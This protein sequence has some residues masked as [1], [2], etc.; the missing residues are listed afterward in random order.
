[1]KR[2]V[3]NSGFTLIEL[4]VVIIILGILTGVAVPA[5]VNM[6]NDARRSAGHA[7]VD[8]IRSTLNIQFGQ[9]ALVTGGA[10]TYPAAVTAVLFSDGKIPTNPVNNLD[11]VQAWD[12]VAAA[13]NTTGWQYQSATGRVRLNSTGNDSQGVPW[14]N[15]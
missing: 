3:R 1:M 15:Y 4:V 9:S 6:S 2:S 12:G 10:P 14:V 11:T 7:A 8:A 13:D 5:Y